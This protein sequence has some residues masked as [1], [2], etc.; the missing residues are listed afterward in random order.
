MNKQSYEEWLRTLYNLHHGKV[1]HTCPIFMDLQER[2]HNYVNEFNYYRL[3]PN[4][5]PEK[6][7]QIVIVT[8]LDLKIG[9]KYLSSSGVP[10]DRITHDMLTQL[11]FSLNI[12]PRIKF[13]STPLTSNPYKYL[14]ILTE[15]FYAQS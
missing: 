10:S 9:I 14:L 5:S 6:Y 7:A 2:K 11:R 12:H 4:P 8:R 15:Y 13:S 1:G 3:H